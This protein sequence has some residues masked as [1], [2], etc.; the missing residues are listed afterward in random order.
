MISDLP[1]VSEL[2]LESN[3]QALVGT[4]VDNFTYLTQMVLP[5][6]A[7]YPDRIAAV[8]VPVVGKRAIICPLEWG[9]AIRDQGWAEDLIVYDENGAPPPVPV[10]NTI[11]D[12][13]RQLGLRHER[14]GFDRHQW[15]ALFIDQLTTALPEV[16]WQPLDRPLRDWRMVKTRD[17]I[18][19]LETAVKQADQS[20]LGALNHAKGAIDNLG[21]SLAEFTERIRVH[22]T[23][24]GG[25][26]A[27]HLSTLQGVELQKIYSPPHG[28]FVNGNLVR[29][30]VTTHQKGY[31]SNAGRMAVIGQPTQ[32]QIAA[33]S[34]NVKLK[35][36]ATELLLPDAVCSQIFGHV[37]KMALELRIPFWE[38]VGIGHGVGTSEREAPYLNSR[39]E[40]V[41][42]P[43]MVIA[44]DIYTYGPQ[45]ELIH[46][47]DTYEITPN[48]NR[49]LSWYRS[50]DSL[51]VVTG[52]RALH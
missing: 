13:V 23:E 1:R 51:Y 17:E 39:D 43:G 40:T 35:T 5:F 41:L 8:L 38:K 31:W 47:K 25:S 27:G 49:L 48:G 44:L 22:L 2:I 15:S 46:S 33:Y 18:G 19:L 16:I 6:A 32:D 29:I 10:V 11:V 45:R 3:C 4:G 34:D 14:I 20:I 42:R 7:C 36:V 9:E 30:D 28:I 12:T 24:F 37:R 50:W 21:Y 52:Y 26:G